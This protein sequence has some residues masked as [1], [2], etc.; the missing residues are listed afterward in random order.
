MEGST[1]STGKRC[2]HGKSAL[3]LELKEQE[4]KYTAQELLSAAAARATASTTEAISV[5][6]QLHAHVKYNDQQSPLV[7]LVVEG[8][9]P[10]LLGQNWLGYVQVDWKRIHAVSTNTTPKMLML[11]YADLFKDELGRVSQF[12]A[13]LHV[14]DGARSRFFKP[15]PVLFAIKAAIK[16]ELNKLESHGAITKVSHSELCEC[17]V[18]NL[19]SKLVVQI[20]I[21]LHLQLFVRSIL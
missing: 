8:G 20:S 10:P 11:K 19:I 6:G 1:T 4:Q 3:E 13:T 18:Y 5:L 9:G 16:K 17:P 12:Q 15:Q 21:K 14:K 2:L 7:L